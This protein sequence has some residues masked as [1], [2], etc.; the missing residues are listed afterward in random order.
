MTNAVQS[1]YLTRQL[2]DGDKPA[3]PP[4]KAETLETWIVRAHCDKGSLQVQG[5]CAVLLCLTLTCPALPCL[6]LPCL[7]LS[8]PALPCL[9]F[10]CPVLP[11]PVLL[12]IHSCVCVCTCMCVCVC[13][14][15]HLYS[16]TRVTVHPD[17]RCTVSH[18]VHPV[19]FRLPFQNRRC[20]FHIGAKTV[21]SRFCLTV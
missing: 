19:Q 2:S 8:C 11:D 15:V 3:A 10:S 17:P 20:G 13:V 12:N 16:F 4:A 7:A 14:C 21:I 9:V 18:D 5:Q 6:P 1:L